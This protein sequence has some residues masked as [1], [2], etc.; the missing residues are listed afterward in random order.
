[1]ISTLARGLIDLLLP[2]ACVVCRRPHRP[3]VD[4]IVCPVC[5]VRV[6]PMPYPQCA[7][8]GHPRL[9]LTMPMPVARPLDAGAP[10]PL[11]S[12]LALPRCRWC[13]RLAPALRAVRSAARMDSGTASA[14]VHALKYQGWTATATAMAR[15][16]ARLEWP[17]DVLEERA[18]LVPVPLSPSRERERGYNQ[19]ERLATALAPHWQLPVW[20]DVLV[21]TRATQSQVRLTP[22]ERAGNVSGAFAVPI[23]QRTRLRGRHVVLVDDVI[24]TAATVNAAVQALLEGGARIISCVTFGRAPD[25]GDRAAPDSASIRN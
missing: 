21:R 7:R 17:R 25:P 18:A 15:R 4:G 9:S 16:M 14:L 2:A 6:Q 23:S 24:T 8:C 19:A 3:D 12:E 11:P 1:M 13:D 22:S 10:P 20:T 5:M